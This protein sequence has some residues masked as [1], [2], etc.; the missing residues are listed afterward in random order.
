M[1]AFESRFFATAQP[2]VATGFRKDV[3]ET[4]NTSS[5][6]AGCDVWAQPFPRRLREIQAASGGASKR[7]EKQALKRGRC[8]PTDSR[9]WHGR[10]KYQHSKNRKSQSQSRTSS[11]SLAQQ[12]HVT[13]CNPAQSKGKPEQSRFSEVLMTFGNR[14]VAERCGNVAARVARTT[15]PPGVPSP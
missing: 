9:R 2:P 6:F 15:E 7:L 5:K 14:F 11:S 10:E 8:V 3:D 1:P 4:L 12:I 13:P